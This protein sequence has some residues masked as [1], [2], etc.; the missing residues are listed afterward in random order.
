MDIFDTLYLGTPANQ[1]LDTPLTPEQKKSMID[2]AAQNH[3]ELL[4]ILRIDHRSDPNTQDTPHRAAR[5]YVNELLAGRFSAPPGLAD[6]DSVETSSA[7]YGLL[8]TDERLKAEF[9]EECRSL[10]GRAHS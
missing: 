9:L 8:K 4:E 2:A 7:Y 1:A 3:S 5:M 10:E 6:F